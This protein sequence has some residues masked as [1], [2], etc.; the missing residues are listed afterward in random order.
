MTMVP[1]TP[2]SLPTLA[3][4]RRNVAKRNI[5]IESDAI[6]QSCMSY[7]QSR[8]M[9]ID[10]FC[11][12]FEAWALSH[13]RMESFVVLNSK[14]VSEFLA[15]ETSQ[16]KE[17]ATSNVLGTVTKVLSPLSTKSSRALPAT[18][19]KKMSSFSDA[20][21]WPMNSDVSRIH[22]NMEENTDSPD[23][24]LLFDTT[25]PGKYMRIIWSKVSKCKPRSQCPDP[26]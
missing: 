22:K 16:L 14:S 3:L 12:K 23:I 24:S 17:N 4:W 26:N 8:Y 21:I 5:E 25:L 2:T 9:D 1:S 10:T 18:E 15:F 19:M 11:N 13:S 6:L 20:L 7:A